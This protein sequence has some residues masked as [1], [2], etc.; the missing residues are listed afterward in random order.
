ML[1]CRLELTSATTAT[2]LPVH[3]THQAFGT[4]GI[5]VCALNSCPQKTG[6][7]AEGLTMPKLSFLSNAPPI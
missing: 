5:Q 4:L 2:V 6:V 1:L 7:S 3:T